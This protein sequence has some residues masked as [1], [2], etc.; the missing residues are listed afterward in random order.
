MATKRPQ[1]QRHDIVLAKIEKA[2]ASSSW[3]A[4]LAI[5]E[6][7]DGLLGDLPSERTVE[8]LV[9]IL[10]RLADDSKWEVRRAVVQVLLNAGRPTVRSTIERLA[11]DDNR[12]VRKA[13]EQARRRLCRITTPAEKRDKRAHFAFEAIK[14]L[15]GTS[16]PRIYQ[17][18]IRVGEKYYEELAGDTAHELNTYRAA[19]E[20][21][22]QELEV[23][24][25][26]E[27]RATPGVSEIFR[28]IHDRSLYLKALVTGLV[29][30]SRDVELRFELLPLAPILQEALDLAREKANVGPAGPDVE[31]VLTVSHTI[32]VEVC[33][34]RFLQ[35]LVNLL[36]NAFESLAG[37][38]QRGRVAIDVQAIGDESLSMTIADT[39]T[40]MDAAQVDSATKRFRSLKKEQGGIGLG[41][42]L[43][44]K[45]I[46][47]EHSGRLDIES[48]LGVGTSVTLQVPLTREAP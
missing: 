5:I 39:G 47:Q 29:E 35:A 15:D 31:T 48:A 24:I 43:A 11:G 25:E 12:W 30:Y 10:E 27:H 1:Q 22:L 20:G 40:G 23:R 19:M 18:A 2:Q 44:V 13:A 8:R 33:R 32:N 9:A 7:V 14:D 41:L 28:K 3:E 37:K 38:N 34:D 26:G 45:I 6:L 16:A 36:S 46:E 42:P 17:A 4:R 21:L